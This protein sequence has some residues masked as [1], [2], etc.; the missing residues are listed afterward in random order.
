MIYLN[1]ITEIES[2]NKKYVL[3]NDSF[4]LFYYNEGKIQWNIILDFFLYKF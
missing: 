3:I 4:Y 1:S 2:D